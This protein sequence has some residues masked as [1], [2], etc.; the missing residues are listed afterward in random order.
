[1]NHPTSVRRPSLLLAAAAVA[2]AWGALYDL[3]RWVIGFMT[4]PV[5]EDIRFDYVAAEAGLRFGW[6]TIYD[7]PTLRSLSSSFP[8]PE[9]S[10]DAS[11]T[12][13]SPPLIA[14]LFVPLTAVPEP[15]AYL[16]WTFLSLGALVWAWYVAAPSSGLGKVTLLLLALALWPLMQSFY[17]GQPTIVLLALVTAAW[18]L[19]VRDRP[20]AAGLAL[21]LATALKPQDVIIVPI[22]LL[23]SG[24]IKPALGW[25]GGCAVLGAASVLTL[26]PEGVASFWK[27]L[28]IVQSD[29]GHAYFT[30]AYLFGFGPLTYF[31]QGLQALI[32]LLAAWRRRAELEI[33]FAA[34]IVGSL[35]CA[36]HLHQVDYSCLIVAAWLVLRTAPPLWHR[37]WLLIG[38]VTMQLLPI[39]FPVP[40]LLWDAGWLAI[41]AA[42]SSVGSA[43]SDHANR[44]EAGSAARAGT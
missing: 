14:W 26:G 19:V 31:L 22:A 18:W 12:Y 35:A 15:V 32:A 11:G 6:S 4:F 34:G 37:L 20:Y 2:V 21:A 9:T 43:A 10:I 33:V 30:F 29:V 42:S 3:A 40:Q 7:L 16:I 24:R 28:Q 13:I 41:L 8:A 1:M 23:A 25:V 39:G 27:T 44:T 17:Y 36:T 38:V 5:H